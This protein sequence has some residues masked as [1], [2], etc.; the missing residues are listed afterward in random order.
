MHLNISKH[1]TS[2]YPYSPGSFIRLVSERKD[3]YFGCHKLVLFLQCSTV[4][5]TFKTSCKK[6]K[7]HNVNAHFVS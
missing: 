4:L 1:V 5:T 7:N 3:N 2:G 6:A